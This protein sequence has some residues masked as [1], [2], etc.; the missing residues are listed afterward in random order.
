MPGTLHFLSG[1]VK[2]AHELDVYLNADGMKKYVSGTDTEAGTTSYLL[3]NGTVIVTDTATGE[4]I[5]VTETVGEGSAQREVYIA[6]S[7]Y[8][9]NGNT[10]TLAEG[11]TLDVSNGKLTIS[12]G[13][14]FET[15]LSVISGKWLM[16]QVTSGPF[17]IL[18]EDESGFTSESN[19]NETSALMMPVKNMLSL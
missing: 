17:T 6:L 10:I 12:A 5:S 8:E 18:Y 3:P 14:T 7:D 4:V 16:D 9:F 19:S 13:H 11:V 15:L 2:L 1:T